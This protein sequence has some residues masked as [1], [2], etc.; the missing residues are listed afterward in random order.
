MIHYYAVTIY[1]REIYI[2]KSPPE[3]LY[4]HL[5]TFYNIV[6]GGLFREIRVKSGRDKFN[7]RIRKRGMYAKT[8]QSGKTA[9]NEISK[10]GL[11]SYQ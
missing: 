1:G 9:D 3:E 2:G 7:M 11:E 10:A 5:Q 6:E 8:H 4:K